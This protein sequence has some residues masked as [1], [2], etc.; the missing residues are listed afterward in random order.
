MEE[1]K[2]KVHLNLEM[3][4][5]YDISSPNNR[6]AGGGVSDLD[7]LIEDVEMGGVGEG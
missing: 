4:L 1:L 5:I 2:R 3:E 7:H 6:E